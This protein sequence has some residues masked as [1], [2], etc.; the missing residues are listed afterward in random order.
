[1]KKL[2]S[3]VLVCI[4]LMMS[5]CVFDET[6]DQII[7]SHEIIEL[8]QGNVQSRTSNVVILDS[9]GNDFYEYIDLEHNEDNPLADYTTDKK[10][11]TAYVYDGSGGTFFLDGNRPSIRYSQN[12]DDIYTDRF[13]YAVIESNKTDCSSI[14]FHDAFANLTFTVRNRMENLFLEI[15]EINIFNIAKKGKFLF[16][17]NGIDAEWKYTGQ[18][19]FISV[20]TDTI[21]V[22]PQDS[23]KISLDN[24]V[25][26]IPQSLI[27]WNPESIPHKGNGSYILL[28]CRIFNICD[29]SKGY[30]ENY[31]VP[32]WCGNDSGFAYVA[33]P[34]Q[35]KWLMDCT[36]EINITLEHGCDWYNI[37]GLIP[38]RILQP[39]IFDATV[40]DWKDN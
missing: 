40:E 14:T 13:N 2:Y 33:I 37:N 3:N 22:H 18:G 35:D 21:G 9:S 11:Y 36:H 39:I 38:T 12:K 23:I 32:I 26:I 30:Q 29:A 10:N 27:S 31:D 25:P 34:F 28:G 19:D 24:P 7:P 4:P 6:L 5:S 16:P 20:N 1:M 8:N 17:F 15:R